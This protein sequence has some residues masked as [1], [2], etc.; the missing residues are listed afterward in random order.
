MGYLTIIGGIFIAWL[1]LVVLFAPHIPYHLEASI[2]S[3]SK[4]FI[5]V[6]ESTCNTP[7]CENNKIEIFTNGPTFYP[8]MVEAIRG[9]R[10]A[11]N[12]ECYIFKKGEV[13]E[14]FLDALC[15]RASAGIPGG[16][17]PIG[18]TRGRSTDS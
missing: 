7:L 6:L 14:R 15:D 1:I 2:D 12:L 11:I 17:R 10:E 4:R 16:V 5:H 9:A 8:A 18:R 3:Q 13:A